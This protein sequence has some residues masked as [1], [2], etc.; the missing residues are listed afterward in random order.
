MTDI[1]LHRKTFSSTHL[2]WCTSFHVFTDRM[3]ICLKKVLNFIL[4]LCDTNFGSPL[5]F[6]P[7]SRDRAGHRICSWEK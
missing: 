3:S 5:K 2:N 1:F 4:L 6:R 7:L